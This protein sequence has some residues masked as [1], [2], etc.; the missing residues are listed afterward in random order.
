MK[1][2][3]IMNKDDSSFTNTVLDEQ[4]FNKIFDYNKITTNE[5]FISNIISIDGISAQIFL[6]LNNGIRCFVSKIIFIKISL[7]KTHPISLNSTLFLQ[8]HDF[9]CF[10][11]EDGTA[12]LS[13]DEKSYNYIFLNK[14]KLKFQKLKNKFESQFQNPVKFLKSLII[15]N[16]FPLIFRRI[17]Q[18]AENA[19]GFAIKP[20]KH[21]PFEGGIFSIC[22]SSFHNQQDISQKTH[23]RII[24]E[25]SVFEL[26]GINISFHFMKT[27]R[28]DLAMFFMNSPHI[29][30]ELAY[31]EG[32][33]ERI[34]CQY[35]FEAKTASAVALSLKNQKEIIGKL[36]K[37]YD[38]REENM[39]EIT[40]KLNLSENVHDI[41]PESIC[42]LLK[43][44]CENCYEKATFSQNVSNMSFQQKIVR[45]EPMKYKLLYKN[46]YLK[47]S[48]FIF[49]YNGGFLEICQPK[50]QKQI[51]S[52]DVWSI[53]LIIQELLR[54]SNVAS[55]NL[56]E[57]CQGIQLIN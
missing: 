54:K 53:G 36:K 20:L 33:S 34:I 22:N 6:I 3:K 19:S 56:E 9:K 12:F 18:V 11:S 10:N 27:K 5:L 51:L 2:L 16:N 15:S 1:N 42:S 13:H 14:A 50:N 39:N 49:K 8:F 31:I 37:F 46:K 28:I 30:Y 24:E 55:P 23:I 25:C 26:E 4:E 17:F 40:I 32:N 41:L 43:Y 38:D 7:P 35:Q 45:K 47:I 48:D 52:N 44:I 29:F 21:L 57:I